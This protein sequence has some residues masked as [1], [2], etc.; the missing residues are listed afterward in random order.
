[1]Y[2]R[3]CKATLL[4]LHTGQLG[5]MQRERSSPERIVLAGLV[6]ESK[7]ERAGG[8]ASEDSYSI[9]VRTRLAQWSLGNRVFL[10]K[11]AQGWPLSPLFSGLAEWSGDCP[12]SPPKIGSMMSNHG[13][14]LH[15]RRR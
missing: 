8:A 14:V 11:M 6:R 5:L 2:L 10:S 15:S 4:W 12:E 1:M 13:L 9:I 3:S 7:S